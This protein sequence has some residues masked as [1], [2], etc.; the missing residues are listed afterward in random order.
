MM[1]KAGYT[2]G[3]FVTPESLPAM[4]AAIEKY[5]APWAELIGETRGVYKHLGAVSQPR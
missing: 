1:P 4:R 3:T 2:H 5:L